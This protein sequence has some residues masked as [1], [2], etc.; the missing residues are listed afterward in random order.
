MLQVVQDFHCAACAEANSHRPTHPPV[1][2]EAIP[3]KW[4]QVQADQFEWEH[5]RK[6]VKSKFSMVVDENCKV[7]VR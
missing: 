4:K 6:K 3:P 1:S 7:R 2:L 5:P